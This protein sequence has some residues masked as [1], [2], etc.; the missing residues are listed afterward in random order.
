MTAEEAIVQSLV[1]NPLGGASTAS[2]LKGYERKPT[3]NAKQILDA[4][5]K[6][7]KL[8]SLSNSG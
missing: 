5:I 3:M 8:I 1:E 2:R 7:H 4:S 6:K